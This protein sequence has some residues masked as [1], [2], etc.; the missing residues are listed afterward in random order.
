MDFHAN[1]NLSH[2][3][4]HNVSRCNVLSVNRLQ[5]PIHFHY[6]M[7]NTSLNHIQSQIDLDFEVVPTLEWTSNI[8]KMCA[9]ANRVM[10][11]I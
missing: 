2:Q 3:Y 4:M 1:Y 11:I 9:K 6:K 10:D 8:K 7:G 5:N